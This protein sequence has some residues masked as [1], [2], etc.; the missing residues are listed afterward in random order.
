MFQRMYKDEP[1]NWREVDEKEV[2]YRLAGYYNSIDLAIECLKQGI[3]H[4]TPFA[5]FRWIE[6]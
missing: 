2:R 3:Q 4:D 5:I 1:D 6:L